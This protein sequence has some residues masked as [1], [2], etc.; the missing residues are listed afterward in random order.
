MSI[1]LSFCF[2][3]VQVGEDEFR[4][5]ARIVKAHGAAVV[6]MAFD[7]EG[8]AADCDNKVRICKRSYD[9]LV[10]EVNSNQTFPY[11]TGNRGGWE[12]GKG[13]SYSCDP[14]LG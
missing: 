13:G 12:E 6:V 8:Q 7:E 14:E 11:Y 4:R 10:D 1:V 9:I 3:L 2:L 5:H